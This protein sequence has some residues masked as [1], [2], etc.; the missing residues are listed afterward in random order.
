L[1]KIS[2]F[3]CFKDLL[4]PNDVEV[5]GETQVTINYLFLLNNNCWIIAGNARVRKKVKIRGFEECLQRNTKHALFK[6]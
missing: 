4:P 3:L 5:Q 2:A 6:Y 1:K